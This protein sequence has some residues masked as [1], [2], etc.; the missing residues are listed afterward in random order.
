MIDFDAVLLAPIYDELGVEAT[1]DALD[2]T[3]T[4]LDKTEGVM[5]ASANNPL[6]LGTTKPAA[7]VRVSELVCQGDRARK[8]QGRRHQLQRQGLE[9][10][11]DP[12]QADAVRRRRALSDPKET[13]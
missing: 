2:V 4:V 8:P 9:D 6:Q 10:R 5:L 12:A 13:R 7:C 1:I 3:L 11:R